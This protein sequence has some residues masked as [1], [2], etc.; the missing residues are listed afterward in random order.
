MYVEKTITDLGQTLEV[1]VVKDKTTQIFESE[2]AL[3]S[4]C[5]RYSRQTGRTVR[6]LK[7]DDNGRR[8]LIREYHDTLRVQ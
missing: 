8:I 7:A 2:F 1:L 4:W 3:Q 5:E 6:L